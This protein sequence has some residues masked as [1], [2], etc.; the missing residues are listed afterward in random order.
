MSFNVF[1]ILCGLTWSQFMS[2]HLLVFVSMWI[3]SY[4][5]YIIYIYS[6]HWYSCSWQPCTSSN[7]SIFFFVLLHI[8]YYYILFLTNDHLVSSITIIVS[9]ILSFLESIRYVRIMLLNSRIREDTL[10]YLISKGS[11]LVSPIIILFALGFCILWSLL[12]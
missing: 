9:F 11:H 8:R 7:P 1:K 10:S 4:V 2:P 12:S 5:Y 6:Y 3:I